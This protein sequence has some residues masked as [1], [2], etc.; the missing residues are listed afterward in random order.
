MRNNNLFDGNV[1]VGLLMSVI[2][3]FSVMGK[4]PTS[5]AAQAQGGEMDQGLAQSDLM[6]ASGGLSSDTTDDEPVIP[7][8]VDQDL[9]AAPY[10]KYYITQD[11]HGQSY[12]HNA[13]DL[14]AGKGATILS[15]ING[16]VTDVYID[17]WGNTAITLENSKYQ[18]LMLHGIYSVEIGQFLN[19]GDVVG[20]ESNIGNTYDMNGNSCAGRDCGHHTHLNVYDKELELNADPLIL[21]GDR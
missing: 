18:V 14:A 19:I 17:Q 4:L 10:K 21:M 11:L 5:A 9:F 15:P 7:L 1:I 12:G 2:I 6:P 3:G 13:V 8:M 20:E 16:I